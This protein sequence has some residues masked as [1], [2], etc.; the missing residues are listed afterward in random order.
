MYYY[1]NL[2]WTQPQLTECCWRL[3]AMSVIKLE[4]EVIYL[5]VHGGGLCPVIS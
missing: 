5:L 1:R 2:N 3:E 4:M